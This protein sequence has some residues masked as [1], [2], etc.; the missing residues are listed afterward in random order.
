VS[1]YQYTRRLDGIDHWLINTSQFE[2][3]YVVDL[4]IWERRERNALLAEIHNLNI[5]RTDIHQ[6]ALLLEHGITLALY[7]TISNPMLAVFRSTQIQA[8][9]KRMDNDLFDMWALLT[10]F[11]INM[12]P[13]IV[14]IN[15]VHGDLII[16][17]LDLI[18]AIT[19]SLL[20]GYN[21]WPSGVPPVLVNLDIYNAVKNIHTTIH[22]LLIRYEK[23]IEQC[24]TEC[25]NFSRLMNE[26]EQHGTVTD[27]MTGAL[28]ET[29]RIILST[30]KDLRNL[31]SNTTKE[32]AR[33]HANLTAAV[34]T[35]GVQYEPTPTHEQYYY[36]T[37][38][39]TI[40]IKPSPLMQNRNLSILFLSLLRSAAE[41]L[42]NMLRLARQTDVDIAEDKLDR[43][44]E[45]I[46]SMVDRTTGTMVSPHSEH[47]AELQKK[48]SDPAIETNADLVAC[49]GR[50]L[51]ERHYGES[52]YVADH[53]A[54]KRARLEHRLYSVDRALPPNLW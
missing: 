29:M 24:K 44:L 49:V 43:S 34:A 16:T 48:I 20:P 6:V 9:Y 1:R 52:D 45:D 30:L 19:D 8:Y 54:S 39:L 47:R 18:D 31:E 41:T 17:Y 46:L 12:L 26:V 25:M 11:K 2:L 32:F 4:S 13:S 5:H 53:I 37:R 27:T 7:A 10:D 33:L 40:E 35:H 3:R 36:G 38:P 15:N 23:S 14:T 42:S 21:L 51:G 50:W 28:M 22:E